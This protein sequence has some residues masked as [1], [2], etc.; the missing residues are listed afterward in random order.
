MC[1]KG[2]QN[3]IDFGIVDNLRQSEKAASSE[4]NW[5]APSR[6]KIP[7]TVE[8]NQALPISIRL[9]TIK[10]AILEWYIQRGKDK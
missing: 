3:G 10:W 6:E 5:V 8:W 4:N 9:Y 1:S 7:Y 2:K